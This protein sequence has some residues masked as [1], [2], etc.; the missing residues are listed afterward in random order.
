MKNLKPMLDGDCCN[1]GIHRAAE[2]AALLCAGPPDFYSGKIGFQSFGMH[3]W[4]IKEVPL[5]FMKNPIIPN[6]LQY[7]DEDKVGQTEISPCR[8]ELPES[9]RGRNIGVIK[10]INPNGCVYKN[11]E[12]G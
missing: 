10:E 2:C 1:Q 3:N 5:R 11:H 6:S 4:K 8:N 9:M 7:L 12:C